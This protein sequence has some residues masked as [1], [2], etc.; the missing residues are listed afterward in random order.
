VKVS[1]IIPHYNDLASLDLCLSAL[2]RQSFPAANTEI[3]VADNGSPQGEAAVS[4]II[5]GR[6]RLVI[7]PEKGAGPARNGGVAAS[8][9]ALLAFTDADCRPDP[10]WL[11]TGVA[12]LS[13]HDFLG[14]GVDVLVRD[15]GR[16][17]PTEAF[18]RVFA[19]D[20]ENYVVE[21]GFVATCNL[22]CSRKLFDAVGGF[23]VGVSED[24]DWSHRAMGLNFRIGYVPGAMV[25]HPARRNWGELKRKWLR[26]NAETYA[27]TTRQTHGRWKWFLRALVLPLSAVAHSG[28]VLRSRRIRG[29][30]QRAGALAILY[31]LRLWRMRDAF[32]LLTGR[33]GG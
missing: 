23:G 4:A 10:V 8:T 15:A 26:I 6:A 21:K 17:S 7:V 24:V 16:M 33:G 12:A 29:I 25:G 28:K 1:V 19:F 20:T 31:R 22:F 13:R 3:V 9:G 5:A 32:R 30:G 27:L 18:E 14:G 2:T 11:E